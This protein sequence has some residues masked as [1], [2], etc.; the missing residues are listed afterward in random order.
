MKEPIS[1]RG[2][3]S[4]VNILIVVRERREG[5]DVRKRVMSLRATSETVSSSSS[6]K[7]TEDATNS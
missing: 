4:S 1:L 2:E 6:G 3:S 7:N 5:K